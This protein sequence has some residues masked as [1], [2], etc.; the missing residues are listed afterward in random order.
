MIQVGLCLLFLPFLIDAVRRCGLADIKPHDFFIWMAL[1]SVIFLALSLGKNMPQG[2]SL[3]YSGAAFLALTLGYSR[4]LLSITLL[5]LITQPLSSYGQA[6]L[7]DGLLPV[8]LMVS[9][10]LFT[11]R[12]LPANPFVFLLGC[13]FIGLF[14]V[15]A[16]QIVMGSVVHGMLTSASIVESVMAEQNA[17]KLLLA[18]GEATLEGM[19]IT[20]LVAYLPRAVLLFDDKFY[21]AKKS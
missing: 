4:A 8:W 17:W 1:T 2:V 6:L 9:L 12:H 18:S 16:A 3:Q 10:V 19:I 20:I 13:S 15:Y 7:I 21:L 5:L 11:R 14:V